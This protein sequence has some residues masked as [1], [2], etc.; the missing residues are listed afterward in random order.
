MVITLKNAD[1]SQSN[2]GNQFIQSVLDYYGCS[3]DK[4]NTA[5]SNLL[6]ELK[7]TTF[8]DEMSLFLPCLSEDSVDKA[9]YDCISGKQY[10]VSYE[11]GSET[12]YILKVSDNELTAQSLRTTNPKGIRFTESFSG[13][14]CNNVTGFFVSL[15]GAS[16][17][18]CVPPFSSVETYPLFR[19]NTMYVNFTNNVVTGAS[20]T[21]GIACAS[22]GGEKAMMVIDENDS[23]FS[24]DFVYPNISEDIAISFN[25]DAYIVSMNKFSV[26][27]IIKRAISEDELKSMRTILSNFYKQLVE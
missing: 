7:K 25:N 8:F 23:V 13:V 27:G 19:K 17:G 10:E 24:V 5:V 2:I 26:F 21:Q 16:R 20:K 6:R 18:L 11:G 4:N 1:F 15:S 3:N 9:F 14:K 22:Y 12:D